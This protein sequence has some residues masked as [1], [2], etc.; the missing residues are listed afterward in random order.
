M[1]LTSST[2]ST[3]RA[4]GCRGSGTSRRSSPGSWSPPCPSPQTSSGL[5]RGKVRQRDV[6][7]IAVMYVVPRCVVCS[8]VTCCDGRG[9][10]PLIFTPVAWMRVEA[11]D[12]HA[13]LNIRAEAAGQRRGLLGQNVD[14][15]HVIF[16]SVPV[17]CQKCLAWLP[18]LAC[19]PR[20]CTCP[21][22][23]RGPCAVF[24]SNRDGSA[25][26]APVVPGCP[27]GMQVA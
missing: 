9:W 14:T 18:P 27:P 24:L 26:A 5:L 17:N 13:L 3:S 11:A 6:V 21:Q 25:Q 16:M 23:C 10:S 4:P 12:T 2:S 22:C 15:Y 8:D 20:V 1:Q 7:V 19:A